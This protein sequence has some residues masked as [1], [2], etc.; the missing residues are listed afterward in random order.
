MTSGDMLNDKKEQIRRA[1]VKSQISDGYDEN[2]YIY[3]TVTK[4]EAVKQTM[5]IIDDIVYEFEELRISG[6]AIE[7]LLNKYVPDL[8]QKQFLHDYMIEVEKERAKGTSYHYEEC[9]IEREMRKEQFEV[10]NGGKN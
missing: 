5:R 7:K 3:K 8:D 1:M 10:I 6:I 4:E 9:D 2:G